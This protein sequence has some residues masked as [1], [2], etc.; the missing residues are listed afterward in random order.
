MR[1][2][3][4]GGSF[5]PVH[6]Q[7]LRIAMAAFAEFQLDEVWF[8][9]V[10]QA[11]HKNRGLLDYHHRRTLLQAALKPYREF[12]VS[13]IEMELGGPSYTVRTLSVLKE[14]F[15]E[16][17]FFLIIGGDSLLELPTWREIEHLVTLTD[18]IVVERPGFAR[19]SPVEAANLHWADCQFSDISS[20]SIREKLA[21]HDFANLHLDFEVLLLILSHGYYGSLGADY[22][23]WLK[24]IQK[25]FDAVPAGL[26]A[27]MHGVSRLALKY[28]VEESYDLRQALLAA[29]AHDLFRDATDVEIMTLVASA[30]FELHE[31][32]LK[33]PML[34][35]GPAA[36]AYILTLIPEISPEVVEAV[37]D[38]TFPRSDSCMLTRILAVADTL[39]PSRGLPA[40]D[41][42][43]EAD[44]PFEDRYQKVLQLKQQVSRDK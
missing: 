18:F 4:I 44:M 6:I 24:I 39:E 2:G 20:S 12:Y 8:V 36:A 37:K 43:R 40:H 16:R 41:A 25:R 5:D 15:P 21:K 31:R 29:L 19:Q 3:I 26:Q 9:P 42:L 22:H 34:A 27:H 30:G 28:A 10:F 1:T 7:H 14:R 32:E 17:E 13:D 11:V 33:T 23:D 35:H 38:H